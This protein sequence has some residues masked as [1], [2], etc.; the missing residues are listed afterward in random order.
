[1]VD[2]GRF[3]ERKFSIQERGLLNPHRGV[4]SMM[5][6]RQG[7][8]PQQDMANKKEDQPDNLQASAGRIFAVINPVSG[9]CQRELVRQTLER[10]CAAAGI[11]CHVYETT[12]KEALSTIIHQARRQGYTLFV[13]AGG[14][15]TIS[16]VAS[17]LVQSGIPLGF[18]P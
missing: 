5:K 2:L 13:A 11:D 6:H 17:G 15:G 18:Y 8:C 10:H 7:T 9:G 16:A 12:G 1:M 14:D 3:N 4:I